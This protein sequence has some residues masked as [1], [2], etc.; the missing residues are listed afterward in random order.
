MHAI[1]LLSHVRVDVTSLEEFAQLLP[2]PAEGVA[3]ADFGLGILKVRSEPLSS[4]LPILQS[5]GI[6]LD[7]YFS[8]RD[9]ASPTAN[10]F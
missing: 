7:Q 9:F 8:S 3:S 2:A 1:L 10:S 4:V 5:Q 6:A